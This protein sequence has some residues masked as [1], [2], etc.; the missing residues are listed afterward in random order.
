[1]QYEVIDNFLPKEEFEAIKNFMMA[2]DFPW[3]FNNHCTDY[4]T[5]TSDQFYF[6]HMIWQDRCPRSQIFELID[7][8]LVKKIGAKALIRIKANLY[9]NLSKNDFNQMHQDFSYTHNGAI[10]SINTNNGG[11][12]LEDGTFIESVENRILFFDPST[13]HQ[14]IYCTDEKRRIN[15]NINYF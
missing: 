11:T 4:L 8:S 9:P 7:K 5:A 2:E 14:P 6:Y 1:M 12:K 3:F 10:F 13:Q 15:I